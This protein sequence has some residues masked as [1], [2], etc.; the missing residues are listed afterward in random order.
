MK[1]ILSECQKDTYAPQLHGR[2]IFFTTG[3]HCTRLSSQEGLRPLLS[4]RFKMPIFARNHSAVPGHW[5]LPS[6][7]CHW[8]PGS[9]CPRF[10]VFAT[11]MQLVATLLQRVCNLFLQLFC[12]CLFQLFASFLQLLL[13]TFVQLFCNFFCNFLQLIVAK[14]KVAKKLP[15]KFQ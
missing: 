9:L 12:N 4:P 15:K 13:A 11:F 5:R 14:K 10:Y 1:L 6:V 7:T 3:S 2:Q 8:V